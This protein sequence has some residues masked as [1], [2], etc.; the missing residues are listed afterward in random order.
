MKFLIFH[1][2]DYMM[3][4]FYCIVFFTMSK[5]DQMKVLSSKIP[6]LNKSSTQSK[7]TFTRN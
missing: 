6:E 4:G 1:L 2:A 3:Q 5:E 7:T